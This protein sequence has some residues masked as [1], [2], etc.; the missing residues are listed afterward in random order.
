MLTLNTHIEELQNQFGLI[1]TK[2]R[3]QDKS[4]REVGLFDNNNILRTLAVTK[5]YTNSAKNL[6]FHRDIINGEAISVVLKNHNVNYIKQT[7]AFYTLN[8]PSSLKDEFYDMTDTT[9]GQYSKLLINNKGD[10]ILYAEICEIFHPKFV[11]ETKSIIHQCD[12]S[13]YKPLL[14]ILNLENQIKNN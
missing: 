3:S 8:V 7:L 1:Q 12:V 5:F 4:Y 10:K 13:I 9:I 2:I 14:K 11:K 6:S